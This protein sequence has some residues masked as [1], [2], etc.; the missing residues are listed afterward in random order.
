M[1]T[2]SRA[3]YSIYYPLLLAL[4][5]DKS[6]DLTIIAFGSHLIYYKE[7]RS[8]DKILDDGFE[9]K[10]RV[11]C[12]P[13]TD[14]PNSIVLSMGETIKQFSK[15]WKKENFNLVFCLGDRYEMFSAVSSLVPFNIKVAH[16]HGGEET[17]GAIDNKFRHSIT[18][19]S[20][21][22][23]AA[24]NLYKKRIIEL[25]NSKNNVYNIGSLSY[26]NMKNL[27][28]FT[29]EEFKLK[30]NIDV[31]IPTIL[32]TFHPETVSLKKNEYYISE[33]ID[34]LRKVKNY[35]YIFT[36]PNT[37]PD[38]LVIRKKIN[39]FVNSSSN[40][41]AIENFGTIGYLSCMK[42]CKFILGNSSSGFAEAA[43][44]PRIV[45][46]L[47]D[48]QKGRIITN[49]IINCKINKHEIFKTIIN[50]KTERKINKIKI[51]GTGNSA[52]KIMYYIK[53]RVYKSIC[54]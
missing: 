31:T 53:N 51:Y 34:A 5:N 48:R 30:Y 2:S 54:N 43:Y 52:K 32:I 41:F 21:Y 14:K 49:N 1:L 35:Q 10:Y 19:M 33:L 42:Y 18:H 39:N 16:I 11:N 23:F 3:D 37:D 29:K 40:S 20:D 36:M 27:S 45:I 12:Y 17:L 47:G 46:N 26:D 4:K 50:L 7:H 9:V 38:S 24:T 8:L 28:F 13:K 15:I 44:F 22:H 6:I 25:I